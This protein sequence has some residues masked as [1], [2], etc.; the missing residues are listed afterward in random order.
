ML[1]ARAI[2]RGDPEQLGKQL[3]ECYKNN[4]QESFDFMSMSVREIN[5]D[6]DKHTVTTEELMDL[7]SDYI[8]R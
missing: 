2:I 4:N 1:K 3:L 8:I 7:P 5:R 6:D